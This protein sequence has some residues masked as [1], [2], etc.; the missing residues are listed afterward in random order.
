MASDENISNRFEAVRERMRQTQSETSERAERRTSRQSRTGLSGSLEKETAVRTEIE[1]TEAF[2]ILTDASLDPQQKIEKLT[3]LLTFNEEDLEGNVERLHQNRSIVAALL[4]DFTQ[5]NKESIELVRDNPLSH[6]RT[7]IKDVFEEY[8][9][10]VG[11]RADLKA[12]LELI[13][14]LIEEKGGPQGL[15]DAMLTARDKEVEKNAL[16]SALNEATGAVEGLNNDIS[17]LNADV[18]ALAR[19]IATDEK[20]AFLFFKGEKKKLLT[21]RRESRTEKEATIEKKKTELAEAQSTLQ[22]R[23]TSYQA[24]VDT[25]DWRINEKIL[26]ILDIG[27]EEFIERVKALSDL[28]LSYIDNTEETL[29]GVRNQLESLL[30]RVTG[31]HTLTH[32][33]K[34]NVAVILDAQRD[35]QEKNAQMLRAFEGESDASGLDALTRDKKKR[36][37]NQHVS[38]IDKTIQST[39]AVS[40]ELGKIESSLTNFKDQMEE[41]L[42]DAIEQQMLAVGSAAV[43]GNNT[44]MRVEGLATFVQSVITKGQYTKESEAA[45]GELA[46]EMERALMGRMAKNASIKDLNSALKEMAD[47]IDVKNDVVLEIAEERKALID[48]LIEQSENLARANEDALAIEATVNKKLYAPENE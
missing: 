7:G 29:T 33:T 5:H 21:R 37:L 42:A 27:N 35:A 13:D 22:E 43:S 44:L 39:A 3:K 9:A 8:H 20:D 46:K 15:I 4:A 38:A 45:L 16:E 1:D 26:E 40:G 18:R 31:V 10:L 19:A 11:D 32:N 41:G 47:A 2:K 36:A 30:Q 23:T 24:F 25:D 48:R 34:E 14:R 28:T 6:L 12:K 17:G